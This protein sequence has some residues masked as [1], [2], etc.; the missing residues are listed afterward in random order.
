[1]RKREKVA[2]GRPDPPDYHSRGASRLTTAH[3]MLLPTRRRC[4]SGIEAGGD[5]L[6]VGVQPAR[7]PAWIAVFWIHSVR[8]A[9]SQC[10]ALPY[11]FSFLRSAAERRLAG[12][13][14]KCD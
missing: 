6:R 1:M 8:A 2:Q 13:V 12:A 7:K 14:T 5:F 11:Q 9:R 3:R 4:G 10:R